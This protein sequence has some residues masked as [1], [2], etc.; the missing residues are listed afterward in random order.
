LALLLEGNRNP[1][2]NADGN[3]V[4]NDVFACGK[5]ETNFSQC[6]IHFYQVLP[7]AV[8]ACTTF[9]LFDEQ[10]NQLYIAVYA[11]CT[12]KFSPVKPLVFSEILT[13]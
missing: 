9:Q 5:P 4:T 13:V 8:T 1:V 10:I 11:G 6:H 7:V 3:F 2:P 12:I